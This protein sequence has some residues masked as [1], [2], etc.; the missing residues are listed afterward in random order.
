[1]R[2][3]KSTFSYNDCLEI[4]DTFDSY[5]QNRDSRVRVIDKAHRNFSTQD[6]LSDEPLLDY[7]VFITSNSISNFSISN[8][9]L[10][11]D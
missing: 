9:E 5:F 6:E 11:P 10:H 4:E 1:M 2:A 7:K 8:V 3:F